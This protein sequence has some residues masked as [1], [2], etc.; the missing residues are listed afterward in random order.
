MLLDNLDE[1]ASIIAEANYSGD[2]FKAK[3]LIFYDVFIRREYQALEGSTTHDIVLS[4]TGNFRSG[5]EVMS[6]F[7]DLINH[8]SGYTE[9][10]Y[11]EMKSVIDHEGLIRKYRAEREKVKDKSSG[12]L[13]ESDLLGDKYQ[14][15]VLAIEGIQELIRMPT[16]KVCPRYPEQERRQFKEPEHSM[17]SLA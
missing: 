16:S 3:L 10:Y 4:K 1:L 9:K 11:S 2:A 12:E 13:E 14:H 8:I 17:Q 5:L 6:F 7:F 15:S